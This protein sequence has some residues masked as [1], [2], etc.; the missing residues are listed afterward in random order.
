VAEVQ[1][2]GRVGADEAAGL[3]QGEPRLAEQDEAL[4]LAQDPLDVGVLGPGHGPIIAPAGVRH[5][6]GPA[7]IDGVRDGR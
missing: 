3:G 4:V 1:V 7:P 5:K 6:A 2:E